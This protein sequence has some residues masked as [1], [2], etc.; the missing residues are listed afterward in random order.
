MVRKST[1]IILL[2]TAAVAI[3][4]TL[5]LYYPALQLPL[6]ADDLLQ[7]PWV[8][9]TRFAELWRTVGPYEDYRP[10]HFSLWRGLLALSG[11][12]EPWM[13]HLLNLVGHALSSGLVGLLAARYSRRPW[14]AALLGT[15]FFALFP[16]AY[17]TVLWASSFSYP[18]TL[19][20]ALAALLLYSQ[21]RFNGK[22]GLHVAGLLLTALAGFAY[23]GGVMVG[24]S[25]VWTEVCLH[26]RPFS[27]WSLAY[28]AASLL[29]FA[30]ITTISPAMPTEFLTGLH[31]SYNL[32]IAL[33]CLVFPLAPLAEPLAHLSGLSD[34]TVLVI[35]GAGALIGAGVWLYR[36]RAYRSALFGLGWAAL[37][38]IIPLATQAFNWY[39]DPPRVFYLS[40]AGIALLWATLV[41]QLP[42]QH[43]GTRAR[44]L[45]Q[46]GLSLLLLAPGA[47]F[48]K[49]E[50]TLHQHV[51]ELLWS[52]ASQAETHS[53]TLFI[54]L[55][56]RITF[57]GRRYP[58]GH[59]G[60]IPLPP[61]TDGELWLAVHSGGTLQATARAMGAILP[62]TPYLL[63]LADAAVDG[64]SLR[65]ATQIVQVRYQPDTLS[66][67]PLGR[68]IPE[69]TPPAHVAGT[70]ISPA[71]ARLMLRRAACRQTPPAEIT[72]E[73]EWQT[74]SKMPGAPTV[75]THW[76]DAQ[77]TLLTQADGDPLGGLYPLAQWEPGEVVQET[78]LIETAV[79]TG[80]V[81]LG[82]WDP[83]SGTRWQATAADG[84]L[85]ADGSFVLPP[86]TPP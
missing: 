59:E 50:V 45:T 46:V 56:G 69:Q 36:R 35:L 2:A 27:R 78:R 65:A 47:A 68:V 19:I 54:N 4:L 80:T 53:G 24:V 13:L 77:G 44:V 29:P 22:V 60:A 31:P 15:G 57:A 75:F 39:R 33:Q 85:L 71:G 37:W 12:L 34:I 18:L 62:P 86:C 38:S 8:K 66:L 55:P 41:E 5:L 40:A 11:R 26:R 58:L 81:T 82:I 64:A 1:G 72:V 76:W 32:V 25:V 63:E 70:F 61:P 20:L 3:V 43:W 74:L 17:D 52:T 49:Q 16:F 73:I 23:E 9:A 10:L 6:W 7:V 28:L 21:A 83:E 30:V 79:L 48:V 14:E 84:Q 42:P 67:A 51:G